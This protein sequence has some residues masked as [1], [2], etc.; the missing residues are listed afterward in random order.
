M[1]TE[2]I[3]KKKDTLNMLIDTQIALKEAEVQEE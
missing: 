2:I 1:I 3:D